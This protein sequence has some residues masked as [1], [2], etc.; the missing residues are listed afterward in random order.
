MAITSL[1]KLEKLKISSRKTAESFQVMFNPDSFS[2][3]HENVFQKLQGINT[4]GRKAEYIHSRSE[5][6]AL[7]LTIDGTGVS[8]YGAMTLVGRGNG[9]VSDQIKKFL[10]LCFH[11]DGALHESKPLKIQWGD[12]PLQNFECRLESVDI[13]YTSFQKSGT[14]LR[15]EL[16]T[17]FVE[18]QDPDKRVKLEGKNSPDLSHSRV[19]RAG[20]TLPLLCKEI[21]GSAEHYLRVARVNNLDDFRNLTPG[22]ELLFPPI[23]S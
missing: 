5:K 7:K 20:D 12:G 3:K 17:V 14:P 1:F 16:A 11:M 21:Y 6:L 2:M 13:S 8:D 18:D 22:Q 9:S 4:S 10:D 19:I 23:Q 15:A